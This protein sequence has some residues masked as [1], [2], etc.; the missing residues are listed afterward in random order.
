[1]LRGELSLAARTI[2][3]PT[4]FID[5]PDRWD[6]NGFANACG[7]ADEKIAGLAPTLERAAQLEE[8]KPAPAL[9]RAQ[10]GVGARGDAAMS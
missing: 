2:F 10:A 4:A 6:C 9:L 8:R 1:V 7:L 5:L 3:D